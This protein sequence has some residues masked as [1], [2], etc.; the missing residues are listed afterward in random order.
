MVEYSLKKVIRKG[1]ISFWYFINLNMKKHPVLWPKGS[2]VELKFQSQTTS[3][4]TYRRNYILS[5]LS[6]MNTNIY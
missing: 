2:K 3:H 5:G 1:L 4:T 6:P